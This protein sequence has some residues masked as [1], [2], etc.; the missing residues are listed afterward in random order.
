MYAWA[1][2]SVCGV[3]EP[4]LMMTWPRSTS[5]RLM[6]RRSRPTFSPARSEEH[7]A[8]PPS[9]RYLHSFPTR[10]S[11]DLELGVRGDRARLD[12]DLAALDV[13]A[14]D[15]TEEQTDVLTGQIGRAHGRTPVTPISTLFPYTTLFRSRTRCAG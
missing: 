11:S 14:L 8:E 6:P 2:N 10:R 15:A 5:S 9:H 4:G 13:L 12:D 3:T 1:S 7:T